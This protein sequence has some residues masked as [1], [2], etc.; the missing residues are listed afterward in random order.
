MQELTI[1]RVKEKTTQGWINGFIGVLLFSGTL[2]AT[3]VAVLEFDPVLVT[4]ARASIAGFLAVFA[5]LFFKQR[6]PDKNQIIPLTIVAL[7]GVVGFPLLSS[8]ALQ[9]VTSAHSIVFVGI[10]PV[11]TAIF[12]IFRG[13]ERPRP[14][15]WLFSTLGSL[16]VV[17]Y[18]VAQGI[19]TS[20]L[21][22]ILMFAAVIVCG[23][24]YAEGAKLTKVLGGWQ[25][26]SRALALSL[27]V[28]LPLCF[29]YEPSSIENISKEAWIGLGYV[30]LLSMFIAFIFW[31]N[32]LAQGGTASVGQI[33][34]LQPFFG[35]ALASWLLHEKVSIGMIVVTVGVILCVFGTKKF[36]K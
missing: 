24:S 10:L 14:I 18:A 27:P 21:S 15:F 2:P 31:Y 22:D 6:R 20:P 1:N 28:M 36:A 34:L 32:G 12:A 7:G 8:L 25:V 13:G 29:I 11:A 17:G 9:H 4:A 33:Q 26:I 16:L 5:L 23:L 19:T 35:L 3:R 30:S